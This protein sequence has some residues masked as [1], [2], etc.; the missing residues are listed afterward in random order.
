MVNEVKSSTNSEG[1]LVP[2]L[3]SPDKAPW[4]M[5]SDLMS[6]WCKIRIYS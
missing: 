5:G 1:P 4:K 2:Q 6:R 3:L